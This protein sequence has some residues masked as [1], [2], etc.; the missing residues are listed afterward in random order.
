MPIS[1]T[2]KAPAASSAEAMEAPV[3][4]SPRTNAANTTKV[5]ATSDPSHTSRQ[6]IFTF[7]NTLY[8]T[9]NENV[10][11]ARL[12]KMVHNTIEMLTPNIVSNHDPSQAIN[13]LITVARIITKPTLKML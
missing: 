2:A 4:N 13:R 7:G 5:A 10:I 6:A 1:R 11:K 3:K 12:P 8:S 9:A